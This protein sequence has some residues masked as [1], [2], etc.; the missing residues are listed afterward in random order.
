[1]LFLQIWHITYMVSDLPFGFF[2]QNGWAA[3][4]PILRQP[5]AGLVFSKLLLLIYLFVCYHT[6]G[7]PIKHENLTVQGSIHTFIQKTGSPQGPDDLSIGEESKL[8]INIAYVEDYRITRQRG[9]QQTGLE[10]VLLG[11]IFFC[12][13]IFLLMGKER[14]R[15][16]V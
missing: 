12:S 9:S 8:L 11:G 15:N 10:M 6:V 3:H 14:Q 5:S 13:C 4:W 1:M 7:T 16:K 2:S